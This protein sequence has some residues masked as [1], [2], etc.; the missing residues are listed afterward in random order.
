MNLVS[1]RLN[2]R[3]LWNFHFFYYI[4]LKYELNIRI[5]SV[6]GSFFPSK[7]DLAYWKSSIASKNLFCCL[8]HDIV[9]SLFFPESL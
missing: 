2:F 8:V 5:I 9:S 7:S 6:L 4:R 3:S 1:D